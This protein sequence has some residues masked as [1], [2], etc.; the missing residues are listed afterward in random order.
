MYHK[1]CI[2]PPAPCQSSIPRPSL[3]LGWHSLLTLLSRTRSLG[4]GLGGSS[5]RTV[6]LAHRLN[7]TLLLLRLDDGDG[8]RQRLLGTRLSFWVGSTH[9]L[10]LDAENTL[11]EENVAGG[12]I[13]EVLGWLTGVDHEAVGELHGLCT[14]SAQLTGDDNLATLSTGLHDEA[15]DSIACSADGETVKKLV[16]EGLAL[17]DGGETTVLDFGGVEGDGVLGELKAFLD[18]GGEL[19]DAST[20]LSEDFLCVGCA[21]DDCGVLEWFERSA[22]CRKEGRL[23]IGHCG[24]K[25]ESVH[26]WC[27]F[28]RLE[29]REEN[30]TS[31]NFETEAIPGILETGNTHVTRTSTPA[32]ELSAYSVAVRGR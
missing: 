15:K 21:D 10:D 9:D 4:S 12:G 26:L 7:H 5:L 19:T 2:C 11:S 32:L 8:I 13:Y 25:K 6:V 23:S 22:N 18:E 14:G 31:S 24:A 3:F 17:G 30:L 16:A 28:W 27:S 29:V 20:L 1:M